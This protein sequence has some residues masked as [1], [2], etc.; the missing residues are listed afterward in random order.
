[1]E[2]RWLI[3]C[4]ALLPLRALQPQDPV[5]YRIP[6]D[7]FA[8]HF[9]Y[10]IAA[11]NDIDG[12]G[13]NDFVAC[14]IQGFIEPTLSPYGYVRL[15]SGKRGDVL[16]TWRGM[17]PGMNFGYELAAI[18]DI[19]GDGKTD[20]VVAA[21]PNKVFI[22][23]PVKD[24]WVKVFEVETFS[25]FK[26]V[27]SR[28]AVTDLDGDGVLD[29]IVGDP[30][31]VLFLSRTEY[32]IPGRVL[33]Y[34]GASWKPIWDDIGDSDRGQLGAA[35]TSIGDIDGDG[36][37]EVAAGEPM[38]DVLDETGHKG[39]VR[40]LRGRDG[41]LLRTIDQDPGFYLGST[42][43]NLGDLDG[44]GFPELAVSSPGYSKSRGWAQGWVGIYSTRTFQVIREHFGIE[45]QLTLGFH[46]DQLGYQL[47]VAGDVDLDG[48][49]D[50]LVAAYRVGDGFGPDYGRLDLRS[51]K[52]GH[53]LASYEDSQESRQ[54]L[55]ATS[56]L[57]DVDGDG[58]PEFLIGSPNVPF[59][60]G[61]HE[62][63]EVIL[64]RYQAALAPFIRGDANGDGRVNISDAVAIIKKVYLGEDLGGC[65]EAYDTDSDGLLTPYDFARIF[66]YYFLGGYSPSAPFPE[67][68]RFGGLRQSRF[69][70]RSSSCPP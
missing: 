30:I 58:R 16:R 21:Y 64:L 22:M 17:D 41:S 52:S 23:S 37:P 43:A 61:T 54:W 13:V 47:G 49:P 70:C 32:I 67:C 28:F 42:L 29:L 15:I 3:L 55:G 11:L 9:G 36:L 48:T 34:S 24:N 1:M 10:A 6:G 12:D 69:D 40:I 4:L 45:G 68:G 33:A 53:L 38:G 2:K 39:K 51:G 60:L 26:H 31:H 14:G 35:V 63:G 65:L 5:V 57:G 46:G 62:R 27:I 19:D 7:H 44:D 59:S 66:V 8:D 20:F 50:Y 56:P 18:G 25:S